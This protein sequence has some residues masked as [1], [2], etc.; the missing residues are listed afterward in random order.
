MIKN[1]KRINLLFIIG[2]R[3]QYIKIS[4]LLRAI[5]NNYYKIILVTKSLI[6]DNIMIPI[7]QKFFIRN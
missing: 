1:K 4:P 3:P 5:N 6:L 2:T 7:C